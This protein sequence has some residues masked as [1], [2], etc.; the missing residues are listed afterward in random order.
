MNRSN[1][2][3]RR[4]LPLDLWPKLD[5]TLWIEALRPRRLFEAKSDLSDLR[6]PT[7]QTYQGN[8]GRWL[9]FLQHHF[10]DLLEGPVGERV[11]RDTVEAWV[12]SL[13]DL[14]SQTRYGYLARLYRVIQLLDPDSDFDW[15]RLV[16]RKL[17]A[18]AEPLTPPVLKARDPSEMLQA[19]ITYMENVDLTKERLVPMGS[20]AFRDG[21]MFAFLCLHP[22]RRRSLAALTLDKHIKIGSSGTTIDLRSEDLKTG[23]GYSFALADCLQPYLRTYI[24]LHRPRLLQGNNSPALWISYQG[25][26]MTPKSLDNRFRKAAPRVLGD[27]V[28]SHDFRHSAAT[29]WADEE[30]QTS[31]Q[32]AALLCHSNLRTTQQNY[33][34][35][36]RRRAVNQYDKIRNN[37]IVELKSAMKAPK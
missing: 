23:E 4:S 1:R 12:N 3:D 34:A 33:I 17:E 18:R 26:A 25:H 22:I 16:T 8:Y 14:A 37:R 32:S 29:F 13:G 36:D 19:A 31:Q 6:S 11:T 30:P 2:P 28:R 15:L 7:L 24:D 5:R 10:P 35:S 9:N 20:S 21:L 27:N